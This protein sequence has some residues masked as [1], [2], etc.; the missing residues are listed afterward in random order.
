[1]TPSVTSKTGGLV[2]LARFEHILDFGTT[3][4]GFDDLRT[5]LAR[6]FLGDVGGQVID[7][8]EIFQAHPIPFWQAPQPWCSDAR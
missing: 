7:H 6:H 3:D 8:V 5:Q 4:D 2:A 1:M